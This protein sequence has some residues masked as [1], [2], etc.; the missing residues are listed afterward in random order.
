[1]RRAPAL[2]LVALLVASGTVQAQALLI[3]TEKQV[4]PLPLIDSRVRVTVEDRVAVTQ[5][6]QTFRNHSDRRL[7]A[8]YIYIVPRGVTITR[9]TLFVNGKEVRGEL[10]EAARARALCEA[11]IQRSKDPDFQQYV[12]NDLLCLMVFPVEPKSDLKVTVRY[13]AAAE[14]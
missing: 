2:A 14:R 13:A 5:V 10:V 4:P 12:G 9:L 6:E 7:E 3:P 11:I 1:M 8:T